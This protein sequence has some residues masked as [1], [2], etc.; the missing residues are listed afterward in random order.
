[1][2]S[3]TNSMEHRRVAPVEVPLPLVER[4]PDPAAEFGFV[5]EISRRERRE[6]LRQSL[7]V[8]IGKAPVREDMEVVPVGRV[9]APGRHGP[10]MFPRH[11]VEDE[12]DHQADATRPER[13]GQVPEVVNGAEIRPYRAIVLDGVAAVVV[14]RAR[15]EQRHEMQVGD[16]E[17]RKVVKVVR[18]AGQ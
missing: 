15:P 1:M 18:D 16:A 6:D 2:M 13:R 10:L 9:A 8:G 12:V 17:V 4:G 14:A 11:M 5:A 3:Q 7:F